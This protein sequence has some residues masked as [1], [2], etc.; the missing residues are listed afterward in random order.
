MTWPYESLGRDFGQGSAGTA[1]SAPRGV[2]WGGS[3]V[4]GASTVASL[5]CLAAGAG[6]ALGSPKAHEP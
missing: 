6:W 3:A 4:T 1:F 5:P 2:S